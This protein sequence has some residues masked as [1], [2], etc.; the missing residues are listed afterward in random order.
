MQNVRKRAPLSCEI[1]IHGSMHPHP[2]SLVARCPY[3]PFFH[4]RTPLVLPRF[5]L[6]MR[7]LSTTILYLTLLW[8]HWAMY[9]L[10]HTGRPRLPRHSIPSGLCRGRNST[11]RMPTDTPQ[12]PVA[13]LRPP[14]L[15]YV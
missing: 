11:L 9:S 5:D 10:P 13:T 14:P 2:F 4:I 3:P 15:R 8:V 1:L 7:I 12:C 6:Q